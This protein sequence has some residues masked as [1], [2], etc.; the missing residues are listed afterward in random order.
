MPGPQ[1]EDPVH[2][3]RHDDERVDLGRKVQR[4]LSQQARTAMHTGSDA[5]GNSRRCVQIV[6]K[7]APG[8]E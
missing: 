1:E 2:A 4:D 5:N 3:V 7:Y 6:R 8:P